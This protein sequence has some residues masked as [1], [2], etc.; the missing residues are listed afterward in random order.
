MVAKRVD[1]ER[2]RGWRWGG[3]IIVVLLV[4]EGGTEGIVSFSRIRVEWG[5]TY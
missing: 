1:V 5:L 4:V 2:E 3:G